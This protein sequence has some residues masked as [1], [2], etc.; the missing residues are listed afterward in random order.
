MTKNDLI[1]GYV[2]V[3]AKKNEELIEE[4]KKEDAPIPNYKAKP[5]M[6][7][8]QIAEQHVI[9]LADKFD[10]SETSRQLTME[11][12]MIKYATEFKE[13]SKS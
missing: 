12:K 11:E 7:F 13:K 2:T 10:R 5:M 4:E 8:E 3:F 1:V 9:K 6:K